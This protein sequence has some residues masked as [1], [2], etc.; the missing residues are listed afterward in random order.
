MKTPAKSIIYFLIKCKQN[1]FYIIEFF[2][3]FGDDYK[4]DVG[5]MGLLSKAKWPTW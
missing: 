4:S 2:K 1:I 3:L 5:K